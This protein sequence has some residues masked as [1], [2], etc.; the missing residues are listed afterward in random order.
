MPKLKYFVVV[1]RA[2]PTKAHPEPKIYRLKVF[3]KNDVRA[4]S[5]FWYH[6]AN[7]DRLK[8]ANGQILAVHR[9]RDPEPLR[10]KNFG[11]WLKY[12]SRS[13]VHN[14]YKEYRAMSV[15]V[16]AQK[17]FND[18]A[19]RHKAKA[20]NV[21]VVDVREISDHEVKR[22]RI[23]QF[24]KPGLRFKN[25]YKVPRAPTKRAFRVFTK[26]PITTRFY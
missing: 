23:K 8:Q 9:V 4:M 26:K 13:G 1:G 25:P 2:K 21:H 18:M 22:H 7:F 16:A 19:G 12:Q 5:K 17:L 3:A 24:L 15:E 14:M 6:I 20:D 10:V 11:F